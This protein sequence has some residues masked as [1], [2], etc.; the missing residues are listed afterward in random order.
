MTIKESKLKNGT[1]SFGGATPIDFACQATNVR[2]T[3]SFD[4]GDVTETLCGDSITGDIKTT[5]VL[6]GT[7]IQDFDDP[8]GFQM[9]AFSLNGENVPFTWKPN[10]TGGTWS[11]TVRVKALEIGGDVNTRL[12]TDF[13]WS[14]SGAPVLTP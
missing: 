6:A 4:E 9:Y 13:E 5:W 10:T 8:A 7:S 14:I 3:P 11:G 1:L 2:L 12:T